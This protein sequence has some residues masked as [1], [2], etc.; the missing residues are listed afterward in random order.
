MAPQLP[1]ITD[2]RYV[3]VRVDPETLRVEV[4]ALDGHWRQATGL[5]TG[6]A[7]QIYLLLRMAMAEHLVTTAESC[8]LILDDVTVQSDAERTARIMEV[9][10]DTSADRQVILFTQEDEVATWAVAN[11]LGDADSYQELDPAVISP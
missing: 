2:G 1:L 10:H 7:E 6:T 4:R 3:D 8:P 11:L 5:S 9:L